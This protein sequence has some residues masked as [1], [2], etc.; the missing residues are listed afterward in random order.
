MDIDQISVPQAQLTEQ[1]TVTVRLSCAY[2]DITPYIRLAEYS[3]LGDE[4]PGTT[5][6]TRVLG[7]N[8]LLTAQSR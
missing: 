3:K 2:H 1:S 4:P 6:P 7:S 5:T 8:V